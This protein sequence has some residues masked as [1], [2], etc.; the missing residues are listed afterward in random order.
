M[1]KEGHEY[2]NVDTDYLPIVLNNESIERS[3]RTAEERGS[4]SPIL[5]IV[6]GTYI[7]WQSNPICLGK[8]PVGS[9]G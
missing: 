5:A 2:R 4:D 7:L 1:L 3:L 8:Y 6:T 9:V